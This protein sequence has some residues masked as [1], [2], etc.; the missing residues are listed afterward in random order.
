MMSILT[1]NVVMV[2]SL[3]VLCAALVGCSSDDDKSADLQ[4]QLDMR[5]DIS[6]E[7]PAEIEGELEE[8]RMAA[9]GLEGGLA[10]SPQAPVYATSEQDTVANLLPGGQTVFSPSSAALRWDWSGAD[11]T[12]AQPDLGAAYV[13][14]I[15][16]DGAGGFHVNYVIDGTEQPV[17]FT[18]DLYGHVPE[19][20]NY[21]KVLEDAEVYLWSWTG[22]FT[23]DDDDHTDGASFRNYHDLHGWSFVEAGWQHRG[24][25]ASG[26]Q[27]M[28]ENLPTGSAAFEGYM[29]GE[30]WDAGELEFLGVESKTFIQANLNLE[31]NLDDGTISGRMDEFLVQYW[32][33][34]SGEIEPLAGSSVDIAS[35]MIAN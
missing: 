34:A 22:S 12:M 19:D 3:A 9:A 23:P 5:A 15:S 17:H 8:F 28:P 7:D 2:C 18:R 16:S 10:R 1:R 26:L 29:I 25:S 21:R 33:S 11:E 20:E 13:K 32:H 14:S 27:T 4:R 6:P 24:A 35:T 30:W 31:A